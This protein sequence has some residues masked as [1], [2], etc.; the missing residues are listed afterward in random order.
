MGQRVAEPL[1]FS[2]VAVHAAKVYII[3]KIVVSKCIMIQ[4]FLNLLMFRTF[5]LSRRDVISV[6]KGHA[7]PQKSRRDVINCVPTTH[8]EG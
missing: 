2:Y 5:L 1:A 7:R 4:L 6:E 3:K 8:K